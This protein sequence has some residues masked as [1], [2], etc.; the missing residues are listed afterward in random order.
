MSTHVPK[1]RLFNRVLLAHHSLLVAII[2]LFSL[3]APGFVSAQ[4]ANGT[5]TNPSETDPQY[6]ARKLQLITAQPSSS[7]APAQLAGAATRVVR[8]SCFEPYDTTAGGGW[9]QI[10]RNDDGFV[11][12][13][14]LG[15][16][17]SLF[18]TI[19]NKVYINNNGNITFN[20]G[21]SAYTPGGF[22]ITTPMIAAFWADVDTRNPASGSAWYK[23]YPDRLV[24]TWNYVGY[25]SNHADKK[26]TF[27]LVIK[28]NTDPGFTGNDVLF[29]YDDMQWTTGDVSG[30]TNGFGGS[31]AT[32][33]VNRGNNVDYI[34]T[35]RFNINSSQPP[36]VPTTGSPGG[37]SW[38]DGICLGYQV[39]GNTGNVPPA[40]AG[41]PTDNT[42]RLNQGETATV[43]LQ[44]SGPEVNQNVNV[45]SSVSGLCNTTIVTTNN[46]TPNPNTTFQVTGGICNGGT[47]DVTFT[48]LDNGTPAASQ[49][50]TIHVIVQAPPVVANTIPNQVGTVGQAF[51]YTIPSNTFSDPNGDALTLSVSGLPA[52]LGF[53]N[54]VISGTPSVSGVSTV[55][56]TATDPGS[57]SVST[58]FTITINPVPAMN[59]P[60]VVA[61]MIPNQVG[62]VGQ[63]FSYTIPSNT[64]SDP[65]GDALTL[66]VSGLPAGLGFANGVISGTPSVS[67]VS[68]VTVTATDPGGLFVSTTFTI[69]INPVPATNQPPVVAN[70]IPNQV[71]TVG[72]AFSYTIPSNT[73]SDPNGDALTLSVSG[74]PAGLG[75]ANGVISGTPSVSGVS[76]VTVTATDPG[77]LFVS[78]TFTI[79]INPVAGT[80][81]PGGPFSI[82]G[83]TTVNCETPSPGQRRLTFVPRYA[84]A[85]GS[86][87]TFSVT[88]EMLPTT[89]AGPYVLNLYIDNPLVNLLAVQGG[90]TSSF[91]YS[92]LAACNSTPPQPGSPFSITGVTTV[93]CETP[94]PGQRRLTFTPR[95]AGGDGGPI[96]FSVTN[97]MLP[98]T[99]AGPYV[100]NLYIDNP[101]VNLLAVQG[102]VT[103]SFAYSWLAACNSTPPQPGSPFS[104]TGVTTVNCET[105]S[106]GQRRLT[107]TPRYAGGDGGP[108]TFSVTNEMLPT[109]N[110]GPYVLNLYID[111]PL[112]NLLAVQGGVTSSFAYSWLA[113]C[114]SNARVGSF[115]DSQLLVRVLGNPIEKGQVQVEVRGA[116]GQPLSIMLSDLQGHVLGSHQIGQAGAEENHTFDVSR[117]GGGIL[118]LRVNTT[119]QSKTLKLINRTN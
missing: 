40:V 60:P 84:G 86:P 110:A 20:A 93:N 10:P 55:T 96:T 38:L 115:S 118:L 9:T 64:F 62:T 108:I 39:R 102:G 99:S 41:L 103:S 75:F 71:G 15:W 56:V 6:D 94:S 68:T 48:A 57:L 69:T 43:N 85:D 98:T 3:L 42:I 117:Q 87:I 109:T 72:Q 92:W 77:G 21:L 34:Q 46:N 113:A 44:F 13:V 79:T 4:Q 26:N 80:P 74:L 90:V 116:L 59:Q 27:Q 58:T 76:T 8:P 33:G 35:G 106:P 32:V 107:F 104:I 53:A 111:N 88:N 66:S 83:V 114:N 24:V 50:F 51:S 37:V 112:V 1:V 45:T 101:L 63:A 19:Y 30:G 73:F 25:F 89:S 2:T 52:G 29:S 119:N 31:A 7:A 12:P 82:T 47:H 97:E 5:F 14:N 49:T 100:L 22:P 54:G 61:N 70:M 23:V 28:A 18:G 105:P 65:N 78:T 91:A 17:F 11:G 36:N 95:Y 16:N 81:P 67:G